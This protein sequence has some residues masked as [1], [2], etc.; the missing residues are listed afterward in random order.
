MENNQRASSLFSKTVIKHI[1]HKMAKK[2]ETN[3]NHVHTYI[4]YAPLSHIYH[5]LS[6]FIPH[7]RAKHKRLHIS[8][9]QM[10][11]SLIFFC[12]LLSVSVTATGTLLATLHFFLCT[13]IFFE[14]VK[15]TLT[16]KHY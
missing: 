14:T 11:T 2:K 15:M 16:R 4:I 9:I 1:M 8:K 12:F 3:D 13:Y 6:H 10:T 5:S 7:Q